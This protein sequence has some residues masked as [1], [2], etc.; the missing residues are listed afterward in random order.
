MPVVDFLPPLHSL[1]DNIAPAERTIDRVRHPKLYPSAMHLPCPTIRRGV[2]CSGRGNCSL[3]TRECTCHR[4]WVGP[5]CSNVSLPCCKDSNC[6]GHGRCDHVVGQCRCD[7]EWRGGACCDHKP[8]SCPDDCFGHGMCN[9]KTCTCACDVGWQGAANCEHGHGPCPCGSSVGGETAG[10]VDSSS[11]SSV[12][13]SCCSGHGNCSTTTMECTCEPR[14]AGDA[15][16]GVASKPC[17]PDCGEHGQC[18]PLTGKCVCDDAFLSPDCVRRKKPCPNDCTGRGE[19]NEEIG[20]CECDTTWR[21]KDCSKPTMPCPVGCSGHGHCMQFVGKCRCF[22]GWAGLTCGNPKT[23]PK[24]HPAVGMQ[25]P[26]QPGGPGGPMGPGGPGGACK[27]G[28]N[29]GEPTG[30]EGL[31][32]GTPG[33]A[34]GPGGPGGIGGLC[35]PGGRCGPGGPDGPGGPCGPSGAG[36]PGGKGGPPAGVSLSPPALRDCLNKPLPTV[37]CTAPCAANLALPGALCGEPGG[38]GGAGGPGTC[39]GWNTI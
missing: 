39:M 6:N 29:A 34:G 27:C 22:V 28:P 33:A 30:T 24:P 17:F 4:G 38:P 2:E 18:D 7:H 19:C 5:A 21:G 23:Q 8:C 14:W 1:H 20:Q 25:P 26:G 15:L 12:I 36:G 13:G 37:N 35:G 9:T 11:L 3:A 16:C 31:L 10:A 32:P